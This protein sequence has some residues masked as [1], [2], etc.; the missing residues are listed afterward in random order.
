MAAVRDLL[1]GWLHSDEVRL[2]AQ[3]HG[4][5]RG[6]ADVIGAAV[7][8]KLWMDL[9][10][11]EREHVAAAR[12]TDVTR[13]LKV[14]VAKTVPDALAHWSTGPEPA[15]D[16]EQRRRTVHALFDDARSTPDGADRLT[17]WGEAI[18]AGDLELVRREYAAFLARMA[19]RGVRPDDL[20]PAEEFLDL[21]EN[22]RGDDRDAA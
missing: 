4:D 18:G 14:A 7:A 22:E 15:A 20:L 11:R 2:L 3:R 19:A 9:H 5:L 6:Q 1:E 13:Y 8:R 10:R 12:R 21:L 16:P 17:R